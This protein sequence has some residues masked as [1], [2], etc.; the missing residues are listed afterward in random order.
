MNSTTENVAVGPTASDGVA[1][2][3]S[4]QEKKKEEIV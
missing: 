1:A 4:T 2:A 3:G